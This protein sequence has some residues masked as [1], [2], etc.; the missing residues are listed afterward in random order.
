MRN[1]AKVLMISFYDFFGMV[2]CNW[3]LLKV[4]QKDIEM[5]FFGTKRKQFDVIFLGNDRMQ[6]DE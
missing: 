3:A 1:E 2:L 4:H 5:D 6:R